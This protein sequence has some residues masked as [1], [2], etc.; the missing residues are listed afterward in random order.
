MRSRRAASSPGRWR[1]DTSIAP[2]AVSAPTSR[3][4]ATG[5]TGSAVELAGARELEQ[6]VGEPLEPHR[7]VDHP[8]GLAARSAVPSGSAAPGA[9]RCP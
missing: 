7:L 6:I 2:F 3:T 4:S 5:S 9:G 8:V 1:T